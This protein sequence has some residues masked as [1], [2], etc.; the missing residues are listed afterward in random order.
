MSE[1]APPSASQERL[2][3]G[4]VSS[5]FLWVGTI[6]AAAVMCGGLTLSE[7]QRHQDS[8][9]TSAVR[10][11]TERFATQITER[12][13]LYQYGLRGA[14]GAVIAAGEDGLTRQIF[15]RYSITRDVG[16]EFAGSLGFGFIRRVF[17]DDRDAFVARAQA[18]GWP[19]FTLRQLAPHEGE[20]F[21]IQYIEPADR[22]QRAIGLDIASETN[23]R[24]AAWDALR[25]GEVRLTGPITLVQA[26]G[27][28]RRSFLI[29]MPIYRTAVTPP[30][31][32]GR[33]ATGF[34]WSYAPLIVDDI[35][36]G[37]QLDDHDGRL[38]IQDDDQIGSDRIFYDN[39]PDDLP[40]A[41]SRF[42]A[43]ARRDLY[44]R[45]WS[46][47]FTADPA[48]IATL[49]LPPPELGG[50]LGAGAGGLLAALTLSL[51]LYGMR[52][53]QS[54]AE[55]AWYAGI[56]SGSLDAI[57]GKTREGYI[58][59]WNAGA[60]KIFG[61]TQAE[62]VGRHVTELIIPDDLWEEEERILATIGQ[63]KP[64]PHFETMR[65]RR[66]GHLVPVSIA[67]APVIDHLGKVEGAA[68]T[69]RDM[70]LTVEARKRL[71][72]MNAEL[73]AQVT[74]R[75]EE[76]EAARRTLRAVLDAVP[77][78][79]GY[80]DKDLIIRIANHAYED[81][82]KIKSS[83]LLGLHM[84]E[85]LDPPVFEAN[86]PYFEAALAGEPQ[87]FER[88]LPRPDGHGNVHVLAH[89]LP[90]IVEGEVQGFYAVVHDV[91]ALAE[92]RSHL[93][94][95]LRENQTL[96]STINQQYLYSVTDT[97][98]VI[99]EVNDNFCTATGYTREELLGNTHGLLNSGVHSID[100]W[101]S[102]WA[103]ILSGKA[104]HG[105]ICNR[106]KDGSL[107]WLDSVI[108][109]LFAADGK[110]ERFISLRT[111]ITDRKQ[112]EMALHDTNLLLSNVLAAASEVSIIATDRT[113]KI[114]LFNRGAERLLG[115]SADEMIGRHTPLVIHDPE[116][117]EER[118]RQLS[119]QQ[120]RPVSHLAAL[121]PRPGSG[122]A[123]TR[124][125]TL[126]R[127]DGST[128][129][130]ML[131]I[132]AMRNEEGRVTG[133]LGVAIDISRQHELWREVVSGRNQL[134]IA[135]DT[136]KLGIWTWRIADNALEWNDRM[137]ELY[138]WPQS[139][140]EEGLTIQHWE[141]R[142]HP[143]D[144]AAIYDDMLAG[145]EPG[146]KFPE[147]VF[148][149]LDSSGKVRYAQL[150]GHVDRDEAGVAI[151]VIGVNLDVTDQREL[152]N[153]LRAAKER[154]DAAS[155]AKSA[156]LANIS[157]EIR[158]PMNA[159]L[160]MLQLVE[161]TPLS[162]SQRD[163]VTK[164]RLASKS[165]LALLGDILDFSKIEAGKLQIENAPFDLEGLML[166]LGV[167][168]AGSQ[169]QKDV[170]ILFD[171]APDI[172]RTFIGDRLRLQQVL[173][174]IAGNALKFTLK[175]QIVVRVGYAGDSAGSL[176][177][178]VE[179]S[180]IGIAEDQLGLIFSGFH[181]AEASTTRR[182]GGTGLGLAIS[183]RLVTL[184][185][186]TL[187]VQ[188][189]PGE[190]SRFWFNLPL[191]PADA[192]LLWPEVPPA[193]RDLKVLIVD[194]NQIVRTA[195]QQTLGAFGWQTALAASGE[196]ALALVEEARAAGSPYSLVLMDWRMP[197]M[198]GQVTAARLQKSL[199]PVP[200]IIM[201][202]AFGEEQ[203]EVARQLP[204][205]PFA[206]ILRK[207]ATPSQLLD[208]IARVFGVD[209]KAGSSP[210]DNA[211]AETT[212]RLTGL[213]VL[214][215]EDNEL[216]R[217]I[218]RDLLVSEGAEIEVAPG[219]R[220]GVAQVLSAPIGRFDTVLMDVQMPD[221]D[222][223]EATRH[224]RADGRHNTLPIVAM[225]ANVS[226]ADREACLAAG[227]NDHIG[228]PINLDEIVRVLHAQKA[229]KAPKPAITAPV[230]EGEIVEPPGPLLQRFGNN[231]AVYRTLLASFR[232]EATRL[233]ARIE[234]LVADPAAPGLADEL[235]TLKGVAGTMGARALANIADR[236]ERALKEGN[237]PAPSVVAAIP[238]ELRQA[239]E[240]CAAR[241]ESW[242]ASS[243]GQD[244]APA[245]A[246]SDNTISE[247]LDALAPLLA[248]RNMR[249]LHV[250]DT[251][252]A[253]PLSSGSAL[254]DE[255]VDLVRK[256]DFE[257]AAESLKNLREEIG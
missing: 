225:T 128:F 247:T 69:I 166:D 45:H 112:A 114:G 54:I 170:E 193:L 83:A 14:R 2:P 32:G 207:P 231:L 192:A 119:T 106:A 90:Q 226:Q 164:A 129:P 245:R 195:L 121:A 205:A 194:D 238:G 96:L 25:T 18:D 63:G 150:A 71:S 86:R 253:M 8:V 155:A 161:R 256:L 197:A 191:Q 181:Q 33:L 100:H 179:D 160:G 142:I 202:T 241:L 144:L 138:D 169:G 180:G 242:V 79:I 73:E 74:Q 171:I 178:E 61:Y 153:T 165:M 107:R 23:R 243:T 95:A 40:P 218:A 201:L 49:G 115:Y 130:A 37:L 176:R 208:M 42:S 70:S 140:R 4:L 91:T 228:K 212:R 211:P 118:A 123:E 53:R 147:Q 122:G 224:I 19:S 102:F 15:H 117:V 157:H 113:G 41:E 26:T 152:E 136:A 151:R 146:G 94:R 3:D 39:R 120:G 131:S 97:K 116:E 76:L 51:S 220:E 250:V 104:W 189:T 55:Q 236:H 148:R 5:I 38:Q 31:E 87:T 59:N 182:F 239:L 24:E 234:A 203:L 89:Y 190:G 254:R 20:L 22:N 216:N 28:P 110:I 249:A 47:F 92:S 80:W 230:P 139:L 204:E 75:T 13:K 67:V 35:L 64:I 111:D 168:L 163:Y 81:F 235:H 36:E 103:T 124:E 78:M 16:G 135:A 43:V 126:V 60:E 109:P 44:G 255:L 184:M 186:G 141:Q 217:M 85:L 246:A 98:G 143:D 257:A 84:S 233:I 158:T 199:A 175:G 6:I 12:I 1:L 210:A 9:A 149:I 244:T 248:A 17:A 50:L 137:Y 172:R 229:E 240:L 185:G 57:I 214:V 101:R 215:V 127:K 93:A 108:A 62:A 219:G 145:L 82:F 221:M 183:Q 173:M 222:G 198:D 252:A 223:L 58:T 213:R 99:I 132:S 206:D 154:A 162:D 125:W 105:E 72:R 21:V 133:H 156:F 77:S 46:I 227:M 188:S 11:A 237:V 65:R 200:R 52:K 177:F 251:L 10:T 232:P 48:F 167:V 159:V 30:T 68:T 134:Q 7:L 34:G 88:S 196:S 209:G 27:A 66:D 187:N 56:V 29:L 174:N